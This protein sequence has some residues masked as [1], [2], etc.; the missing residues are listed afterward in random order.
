MRR[1][2]FITLLGSAAAWSSAARE[3]QAVKIPRIG[4]LWPNPLAASGQ[5][6][7]AFRQRLRELGYVEGRQS[8]KASQRAMSRTDQFK[9][10]AACSGLGSAMAQLKRE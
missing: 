8:A 4:I 2:E 1:R 6:V 10:G 7:D 9:V 5:F 3:Q